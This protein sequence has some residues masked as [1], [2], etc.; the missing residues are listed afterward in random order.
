MAISKQNLNAK[1]EKGDVHRKKFGSV[2]V[3]IAFIFPFLA[4]KNQYKN[5]DQVYE[6]LTNNLN[7]ISI[8]EYFEYCIS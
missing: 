4:A 6:I 3:S 1:S 7:E 5:F 8:D 2:P